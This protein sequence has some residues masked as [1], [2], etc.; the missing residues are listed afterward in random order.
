MSAYVEQAVANCKLTDISS[1]AFAVIE[2][3]DI[4]TQRLSK[5]IDRE[6][7]DMC[8][9]GDS[10][11]KRRVIIMRQVLEDL[12]DKKTSI[13]LRSY[14]L[15]DQH[16]QLVD[17]EIKLLETSIKLHGTADTTRSKPAKSSG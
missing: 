9:S 7:T 5:K 6:V 4:L 10:S 17:K 3:L 11:K 15:L 16:I 1:E 8:S 14:D 13:A 12:A 2:N